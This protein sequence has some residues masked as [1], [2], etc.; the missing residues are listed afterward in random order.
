MTTAITKKIVGFA[1]RKPDEKQVVPAIAANDAVIDPDRR[2]SLKPVR[3]VMNAMRWPHRPETPNGTPSWTS[4][5][6]K[7]PLGNFSLTVGL[8]QNGITHPF[9]VWVNGAEAPRGLT[10][11]AKLLSFDMRLKDPVWLEGK[12]EALK[13]TGGDPITIL[14]PGDAAPTR[15]GSPVAAMATYLEH[16]CR[17]VGYFG[18]ATTSPM[19]ETMICDG[20]PKTRLNGNLAWYVDVE[21]RNTGDDFVVMVKEATIDGRKWPFSVWFSGS[22]PRSWDGLC[23]SLSLDMQ[24]ADPEWIGAKLMSITDHVE[25]RS[26]FFAEDPLTGKGALMPSTLAYV[27]RLLLHRYQMLGILDAEGRPTA[28][29]ALFER[30]PNTPPQDTVQNGPQGLECTTCHTHSVFRLDGCWVCTACGSSRCG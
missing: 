9:E 13:G 12:L 17:E 29:M 22:Y 15:V 3:G 16:A 28:P 8:Y 5:W 24:V 6:V 11:L 27:A 1:V 14:R 2:I 26:E 30:T 10:T 7:S 19:R 25:A 20:E 23:K 21:N 18:S 4:P